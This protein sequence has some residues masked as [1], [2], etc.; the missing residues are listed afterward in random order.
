MCRSS[1][2]L[3]S[4]N[5]TVKPMNNLAIFPRNLNTS[6][7]DYEH[8]TPSRPLEL[9]HISGTDLGGGGGEGEIFEPQEFFFVIKFL[10]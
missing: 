6:R 1:Q 8:T 5:S 4:S 3:P 7:S 9:S 2:R 10:V